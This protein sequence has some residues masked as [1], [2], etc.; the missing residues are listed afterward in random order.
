MVGFDRHAVAGVALVMAV[1]V[2]HA[3]VAP[4]LPESLMGALP[5]V[6]DLVVYPRSGDVHV[7]RRIP[8]RDQAACTSARQVIDGA[9][10]DRDAWLAGTADLL[11]P[12]DPDIAVLDRA[13]ALAA[14]GAD[15]LFLVAYRMARHHADGAPSRSRTLVVT[16]CAPKRDSDLGFSAGSGPTALC[17]EAE[18][19]VEP[20]AES[21]S[22]G[23]R[24][25]AGRLAVATTAH[26]L[27]I[28]LPDGGT[29]ITAEAVDPLAWSAAHIRRHPQPVFA[30]ISITEQGLDV[31]GAVFRLHASAID[32]A[33]IVTREVAAV[34]GATLV[35]LGSLPADPSNRTPMVR[36]AETRLFDRAQGARP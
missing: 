27:A 21:Q 22:A 6:G 25:G 33:L 15:G 34:D 28:L 10:A 36:L 7:C 5:G 4:R 31:R 26:G 3:E 18:Y 16:R 11:Y 1:S 8:A 23:A 19:H 24:D 12:R 14:D 2:T 29:L 17:S 30:P 13:I 9:L 32:D 35:S 20:S